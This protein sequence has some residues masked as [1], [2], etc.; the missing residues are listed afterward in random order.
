MA[1]P[2][3]YRAEKPARIYK[4]PKVSAR[5]RV[6]NQWRRLD[7]TD[8][9]AAQALTARGVH[10]IMPNVL[11]ELRI[12]RR[13]AEAEIVRVW[14]NLLDPNIVAHAQPTGLNKGTLFV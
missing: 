14:G 3:R 1:K 2:S 12:D 11:S 7:L 13:A 6:L 4:G 8:E 10:D 9:K 5:K